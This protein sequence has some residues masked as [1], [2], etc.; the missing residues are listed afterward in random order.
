MAS[1]TTASLD[2]FT[3]TEYVDLKKIKDRLEEISLSK[4]DSNYLDVNLKKFK[5]DDNRDF[6]LVQIL[7][8]GEADYN[9]FIRLRKQLVNAAENYGR[10]EN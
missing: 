3:C 6:R 8:F 1:N 4:N 2:K 10:E 9:R 5:R 7:T